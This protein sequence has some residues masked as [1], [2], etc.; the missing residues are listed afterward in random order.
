M[1]SGG[2]VGKSPAT[3]KMFLLHDYLGIVFEQKI[4][5]SLSVSQTVL[6]VAVALNP[7]A[8]KETTMLTQAVHVLS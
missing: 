3:P 8:A 1:E 7:M 4:V 6:L 2:L 5:F